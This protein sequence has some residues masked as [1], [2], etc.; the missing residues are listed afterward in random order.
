MN[1]YT[2]KSGN[3]TAIFPTPQAA[4]LFQK[5]IEYGE[6]T[7]NRNRLREGNEIDE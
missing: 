3:I 7:H 5:R 1:E 6:K 4:E 2:V